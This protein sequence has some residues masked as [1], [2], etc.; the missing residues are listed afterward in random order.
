MRRMEVQRVRA[1]GSK[2]VFVPT[3][4]FGTQIGNAMAVGLGAG[5]GADARK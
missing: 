1:Y 3:E 5:I 2:A 4:G